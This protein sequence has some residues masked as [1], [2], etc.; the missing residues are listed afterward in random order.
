MDIS[1]VILSWNDKRYL[2]E[3][4]QSLVNCTKSRT[5]EIIVVDN[6]STDGSPEMVSTN[7]P[8]V[9][10]IRNRENLGF[11]KGNNVGIQAATGKYLF[12]LNSDI[13]VLD[14]C[15]DALADY[16]DAQPDVGMVGPKILNAD[17]THQSSC[18]RFP[19]LWNNFC[20][21]NGLSGMFKKS[22]FFSGEHM[23][24]FEGDQLM[25]VD[26]LVG[27][28][29]ALRRAALDNFGML[30]EGFF[31]YA[32]DVDW[33]KRCWKSGWRV[34]FFPDARAIHYRG[35][36]SA[37]QDPI[38]L[39]LT[40]QR[41]TLRYWRKHH[42]LPGV[43]AISVLIFL[44]K[45]IRCALACINYLSRPSKRDDSRQRLRIAGASLLALFSR[46]ANYKQI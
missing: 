29:W 45:L 41:S 16:L 46:N 23:F 20:M 33:C 38:W 6:A 22:R 40:Q 9:K 15:F 36:S 34:V 1:V 13:K 5:V 7:F 12:L 28:F 30:D 19:M 21:L 26:V 14:G 25:D 18:R 17:M 8:T 10:L 24:Y 4:L 27:C 11:P 3:C 43:L 31:M 35:G 44:S 42:G 32:E 39:A 2:E 37:K